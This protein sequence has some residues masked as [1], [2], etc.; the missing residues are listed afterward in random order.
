M[1]TTIPASFLFQ[2]QLTLPRLDEMPRSR[3]RLLGLQNSPELFVPSRL[4]DE[5]TPVRIRA[6]WNPRGLGLLLQIRGRQHSPAGRWKDPQN[7]DWIHILVD[8][9]HAAG[10]QRATEFCTSV[11][12]MPVDDDADG[13][14]TVRF[15]DISRQRILTGAQSA[16]SARVDLQQLTGGYD[17]ELWLPGSLLPGFTQIGE[18]GILGF[19]CV[20][21]DTELGEVPLNVGGDFPVAINPSTWLVLALQDA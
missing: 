21:N 13:E 3:G 11:A 1:P 9:R 19:Y 5:T 10:V 15:T 2:Y 16:D 8:T 6:A 14:S 17:L 4:N 12:V 20:V 7:S 18:T